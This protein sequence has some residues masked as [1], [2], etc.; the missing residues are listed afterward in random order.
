MRRLLVVGGV[1]ATCL[2][3]VAAVAFAAN[4]QVSYTAKLTPAHPKPK[5]GKPAN[6][7]YEGILS[8]TTSD[9]TQ[10][11]TGAKTTLYFPKQ[12]QNNAKKFPSCK[13]SE[14]D[15]KDSIPSK[16]KSAIVGSGTAQSEAPT[17]GQPPNPALAETL[18]VTA[19]NGDKGK[20]LMLVLNAAAPVQILNRVIP[21]KLGPGGGAFGYTVTFTVPP[22]LQNIAGAQIALAHFEVKISAKK[23][24][25]VKGKKVSYLQLKSCPSSKKLPT[26]TTIDFDNSAGASTGA[27]AAG[28]DMTVT[29]TM[30][31]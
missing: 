11:D 25:K 4:N 9:G 2:A 13:P 19:M 7:G 10:P 8:V 23:T 29:G 30:G 18:K 6:V 5:A 24:A 26:K 22:D 20:T 27:P 17:P 12:L 1:V 16:C 14:I 3:V 21:G 31:C 15:G 28:P